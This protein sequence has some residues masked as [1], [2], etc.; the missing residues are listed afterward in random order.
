[1]K[2]IIISHSKD[3]NS[4][5]DIIK[6]GGLVAAPTETV[7]GLCANALNSCAVSNIFIAKGRPSD[8]PLIVHIAGRDMLYNLAIDVSEEAVLL[9]DAFWP[10]PLTLVFKASSIVPKIVTGGLDTVAVR[11]PSHPTMQKLINLSGFP[12]AAPSA[13]T[14]GK[15][16]PT[17]A[18]RVIEDLDGKVEAIIDGGNSEFGVESTVL[19]MT[20]KVPTILRPGG[21]TLE[22]LQ[23]VL[24][25]VTVDPAIS[26]SLSNNALPKAPGMKYTHYSPNA[27]VFI[28][29]GDLK[30]V[31]DKINT[32]IQAHHKAGKTVGVLATEETKH[33]FNANLTLSVGTSQN[34]STI[35]AQL[36]EDLRTFDDHHMDI[37]YSLA[38]PK[39]GIGEA[40]MNRL[41]KSAAHNIIDV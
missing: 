19:D 1:M 23:Q 7:Y 33:L 32:L 37:V 3:L 34:L 40:I 5:A 18:K 24:E 6:K 21:I 35:A 11:F 36:F 31:T 30:K 12:L 14:S 15:P 22:M 20:S 9:M 2:T 25:D 27:E 29:R 16:S 8:N 39:T 41:E 28:V 10:G 17:N 38:F 13:N 26:H 4:A